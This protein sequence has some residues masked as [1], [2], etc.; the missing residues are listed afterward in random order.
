MSRFGDLQ[1]L[2]NAGE[3]PTLRAEEDKLLLCFNIIHGSSFIH[4]RL[5]NPARPEIGVRIG[6]NASERKRRRAQ[7]HERIVFRNELTS[8]HE[9]TNRGRANIQPSTFILPRH[10]HFLHSSLR[11]RGI[12]HEGYR[13][14]A[15]NRF[16]PCFLRITKSQTP[17]RKP[18]P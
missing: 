9:T 4:R 17:R 18:Q 8:F 12:S 7:G 3:A 1:L 16:A 13:V 2:G 6:T 14:R 15:V 5:E 10:I 11:G